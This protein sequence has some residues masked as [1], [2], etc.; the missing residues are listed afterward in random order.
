MKYKVVTATPNKF[1]Q[2]CQEVINQGFR[3][4]SGITIDRFYNNQKV[5][6]VQS[7]IEI[8]QKKYGQ[9]KKEIK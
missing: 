1:E 6:Y 8:D 2:E 9:T 7:F 4:C 5:H 3:P